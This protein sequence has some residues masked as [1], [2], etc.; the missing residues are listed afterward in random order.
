MEREVTVASGLLDVVGRDLLH[1][2][3]MCKGDRKSTNNLKSLAEDLFADVIPASWRKY[4]V[5]NIAATEWVS[6]FVKRV[7]QLKKLSV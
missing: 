1:L 6:D 5:A 3:E 2:I 7:V 4:T